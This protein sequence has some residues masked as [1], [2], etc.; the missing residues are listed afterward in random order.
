MR[1]AI[2]LEREENYLQKVKLLHPS[3]TGLAA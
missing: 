2:R 1:A 3:L